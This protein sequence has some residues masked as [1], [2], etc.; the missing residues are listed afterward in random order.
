MPTRVFISHSTVDAVVA[1]EIATA[2]DSAGLS[3]WIDSR[4]IRPGDS[5]LERMNQGISEA[6]YV[7]LLW[8]E[9]AALSHWVMREW[10]SA[11]ASRGT[12]VIPV[13]LDD[14]ERPALLRDIVYIDLRRDRQAGIAALL[15]F[16]RRETSP[17]RPPSAVRDGGLSLRNA[18][19]R[20]IRL[21]ALR[22]L[23]ET[24]LRS[25]CFDAGLDPGS[26]A[27]AS[28]H[29][30]LVSLLHMAATEGLLLRFADWLETERYRCVR[31]QVDELRQ[32]P[33]WNWSA[34]V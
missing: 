7:L 2:L 15:D 25:F 11:A 32:Q 28:L 24:G 6:S 4:E 22:C 9:A 31:Y 21:V 27:G 12:V 20:Q 23:D 26:L 5:F 34:E 16:F 10:M 29:E 33:A 17:L 19:R 8:S 30:K 1:Q 13:L 18:S 3:P 14:S